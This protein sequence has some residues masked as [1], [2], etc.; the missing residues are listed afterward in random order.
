MLLINGDFQKI[1][2]ERDRI[3]S[4]VLAAICFFTIF[5]TFSAVLI[6]SA[7]YVRM[8]LWKYEAYFINH[9]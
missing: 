9:C 3:N 5:R 4:E 7:I 8:H 1:K 2:G 6:N